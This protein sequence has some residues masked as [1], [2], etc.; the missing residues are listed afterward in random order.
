MEG[1]E[2]AALSDEKCRLVC[3]LFCGRRQCRG[4]FRKERQGPKLQ[5]MVLV[6]VVVGLAGIHGHFELGR[7]N[8]TSSFRVSHVDNRTLILVLFNHSLVL[9]GILEMGKV[10]S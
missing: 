9:L 5:R 7:G 1:K 8:Q 6:G 10:T 3:F 2:Y 4:G